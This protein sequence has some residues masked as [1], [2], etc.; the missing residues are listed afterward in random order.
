MNRDLLIHQKL[1]MKEQAG[2]KFSHSS[3]KGVFIFPPKSV[4]DKYGLVE[5]IK[6][7]K[8]TAEEAIAFIEGMETAFEIQKIASFSE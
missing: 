3:H 7:E 4:I 2:W 8:Q 5:K 1:S 6:W